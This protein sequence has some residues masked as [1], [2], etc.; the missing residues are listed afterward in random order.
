MKKNTALALLLLNL[1]SFSAFSAGNECD[2]NIIIDSLV[3]NQNIDNLVPNPVQQRII[4]QTNA[5]FHQHLKK[6]NLPTENYF[7]I[8]NITNKISYK[9]NW[10]Y[11][12]IS[13]FINIIFDLNL[14]INDLKNIIELSFELLKNTSS[15]PRDYEA[16]SKFILK[17][18]LHN[19]NNVLEFLKDILKDNNLDLKSG[20][21]PFI[22]AICDTSDEGRSNLLDWK[23]NIFTFLP[24]ARI[25]TDAFSKLFHYIANNP[26][27][28]PS[29]H[30]VLFL[31]LL[32]QKE[33]THSINDT[34]VNALINSHHADF[35]AAIILL[36]IIFATH[37]S[38]AY[39]DCLAISQYILD[40]A[41][42]LEFVE[43]F[44]FASNL[45]ENS[46]WSVEDYIKYVNDLYLLPEQDFKNIAP[47]F[48]KIF[49]INPPWDYYN[50]QP[51]CEYIIKNH[52]EL[53]FIERFNVSCNLLN[54]KKICHFLYIQYI[55]KICM[56]PEQ[57][58]KN[59]PLL[60]DTLNSVNSSWTDHHFLSIFSEVLNKA[61]QQNFIKIFNYVCSIL[62]NNINI[63]AVDFEDYI[64]YFS[65]FNEKEFTD[66][67][68]FFKFLT[69]TSSTKKIKRFSYEDEEND[70]FGIE[71]NNKWIDYE[72]PKKFVKHISS[73]FK[74]NSK[75]LSDIIPK[76]KSFSEFKNLVNLIN[77]I[78]ASMDII[79]QSEILNFLENKNWSP[80]NNI[81]FIEYIPFLKNKNN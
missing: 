3:P 81:K 40:R 43:R 6:K 63:K 33:L 78:C 24:C 69:L 42:S 36:E 48:D 21:T 73:I 14:N 9:E 59:A 57:T 62:D 44:D 4:N 56:L 23:K 5:L 37:P 2:N 8:I 38:W 71:I 55:K 45:I 68:F 72:T 61:K 74:K 64:E 16:L 18:D 7:E 60:F 17:K 77:K 41:M 31:K 35:K 27:Q 34:L 70:F 51:I 22:E 67:E 79:E 39:N 26:S 47:L 54:T 50:Y 11:Y 66:F 28:K 19:N 49:T 53:N 29:E 10:N 20:L 32:G 1:S 15:K 65:L 80:K 30:H 52:K 76:H 46:N 58:F 75:E 12:E 25:N 13:R